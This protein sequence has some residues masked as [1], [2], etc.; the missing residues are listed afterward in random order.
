MALFPF[1]RSPFLRWREFAL[2][3]NFDVFLLVAETAAVPH[4]TRSTP[5]PRLEH[6]A[7]AGKHRP[8][9][10]L[11]TLQRLS[12]RVHRKDNGAM[13]SVFLM[14]YRI[15]K[16]NRVSKSQDS[17]GG[18]EHRALSSLLADFCGKLC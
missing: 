6:A 12:E 15:T 2:S 13:K 18:N 1:L 8:R 9:Q 11:I 7:A 10:R 5:R 3:L 17:T 16:I 14:A 4:A